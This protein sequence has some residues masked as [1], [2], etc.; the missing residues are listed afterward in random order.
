MRYTTDDI[1]KMV[2]YVPLFN[3]EG[4]DVG[5][6]DAESANAFDDWLRDV[7]DVGIQI[8]KASIS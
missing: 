4:E 6:W 7:E 1:R 5:F 8:G 3:E 2:A